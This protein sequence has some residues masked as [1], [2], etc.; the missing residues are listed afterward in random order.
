VIVEYRHKPLK[1]PAAK[2]QPARIVGPV[3]VQARK[4]GRFRRTAEPLADDPAANERVR[5]FFARMGLTSGA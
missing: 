2:V 3:I 1:R 4:P 5:A